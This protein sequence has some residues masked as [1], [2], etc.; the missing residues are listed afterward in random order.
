[1]SASG[2]SGGYSAGAESSESLLK[3]KGQVQVQVSNSICLVHLNWQA[4]KQKRI[5]HIPL[6]SKSRDSWFISK[7]A[8]L[9]LFDEW[10]SRGVLV[11]GGIN[12]FII[13][14][15]S[16]TNEFAAIVAACE[17]DDGNT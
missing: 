7:N 12:V 1:M 5:Q 15:V 3:G 8:S 13:D 4:S 10:D 11:E 14:V 16:N 2:W 17:E 6:D 9:D